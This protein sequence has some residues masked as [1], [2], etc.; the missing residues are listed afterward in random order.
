MIYKA[1]QKSTKVVTNNVKDEPNFPACLTDTG[2][3]FFF[4]AE[5]GIRDADVTG[6]QTCALPILISA[7]WSASSW[8]YA[9]SASCRCPTRHFMTVIAR[10]AGS[11][12]PAAPRAP[13]RPAC[14][15]LDPAPVSAAPGLSLDRVSAAS[16]SRSST[17]SRDGTRSVSALPPTFSRPECAAGYAGVSLGTVTGS[18]RSTLVFVPADVLRR[19]ATTFCNRPTTRG[20]GSS[21]PTGIPGRR[22]AVDGDGAAARRLAY[23]VIVGH[24]SGAGIDAHHIHHESGALERVG[25]LGKGHADRGRNIDQLGTL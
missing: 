14:R 24:V 11:L 8:R 21:A 23:R 12:G 1:F 22:S 7:S 17:S 6:V 15:A 10:R 5:D 25:R 19:H 2:S 13:Q 18:R 3:F 16:S 4:Q 9:R 20:K